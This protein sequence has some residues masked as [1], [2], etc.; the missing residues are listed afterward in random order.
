LL[1][2]GASHD[3]IELPL[4]MF[5]GLSSTNTAIQNWNALLSSGAAVQSGANVTITD[6]AHDILTLN[7]VA[8][9]A[10]SHD[11]SNAFKFV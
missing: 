10:L 9:S 6:A 2:S 3:A 8:I 7:N 1:T 11:A 4:T 5:K